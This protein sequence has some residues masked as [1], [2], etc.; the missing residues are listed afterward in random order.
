M[1]KPLSTKHE[2]NI[3]MRRSNNEK[4]YN[5]YRDEVCNKRGE[6]QGNLTPE[7]KDGLR[8]LQKQIKKHKILVLKTDKSGK[9]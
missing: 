3:E 6:V 7:E 5:E 4:I 8:S 1:P 9:L 2:A